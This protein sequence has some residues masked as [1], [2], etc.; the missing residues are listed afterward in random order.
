MEMYTDVCTCMGIMAGA[1]K[2]T[3]S[4]FKYFLFTV[5]TKEQLETSPG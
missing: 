3:T 1:F 5:D 2:T 4:R